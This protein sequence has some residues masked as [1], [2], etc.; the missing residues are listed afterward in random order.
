MQR[1][2]RPVQRLLGGP[3]ALLTR[4]YGSERNPAHQAGTMAVAMLLVLLVTG[5]YLVLVYR[6]GAP[7]ESVARMA[8]DPWLG[9]WMRTLHRYA[10]DIFVLATALHAARMFSQRRS[11]GPRTMAWL[12]GLFLLGVGVF[13]AWTGFVMAWDSFGARLALEG[14]RL[15]DLLPIFSEPLSR[16]FSGEGPVPSA[17]FFVNLFLHIAVPLGIGVGALAAVS[18]LARPVLLPPKGLLWATIAAITLASVLP[19]PL[20]PAPDSLTMVGSTPLDLFVG[21]WLP[22]TEPLPAG[23]VWLAG[24]AVAL[25]ALLVPRLTRPRSGVAAASVVD[26]RFCTG[27][28]QCPQDCP[29]EAITMVPRSDG[30]PTLLAQVDPE[31]CVSCGICAGSCK[32]M[33]VGPRGGAAAISC[34]TC[35][36]RCCPGS[37]PRSRSASWPSAAPEHSTAHI[38]ALRDS[39][40]FVHPVSCVGNLHSSVIEWLIRSGAPGVITCGCPPRDCVNRE[41]PKW[42]AE[43]LYHDREAELQPRVDRRRVRIATLAPGDLA[44]TVAAF[45]AFRRALATLEP[46]TAEL[47]VDLDALCDTA[48]LDEMRRSPVRW[49]GAFIGTGRRCGWWHAS[50]LSVAA[51]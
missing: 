51:G 9:G 29:W 44:G 24:G 37:S 15:L 27:C 25:L 32:P 22:L 5:L 18:R 28:N 40:A 3:D 30:R 45:E 33:G 16:I 46:P 11:W 36:R 12:S 6:V 17:F 31:R 47:E 4:I 41:G 14:A 42:L 20:G 35:V 23:V 21:W 2:T 13:T 1:L 26:P 19:A 7:F 39:G 34:W 43:R 50:G 38:A 49:V 48:P 8:A 10:T